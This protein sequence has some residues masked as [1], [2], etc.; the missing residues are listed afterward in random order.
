MHYLR[1]IKFQ[2]DK[3][4]ATG[5]LCAF[6]LSEADILNYSWQIANGMAYLSSKSIVHRDLSARNILISSDSRLKVSDFG[7]SRVVDDQLV[8]ASSASRKLPIRWMS[9]ESI[10]HLK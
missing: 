3:A 5:E 9:P 4:Q 6:E 2:I 7:L 10:L 8:Y 1:K